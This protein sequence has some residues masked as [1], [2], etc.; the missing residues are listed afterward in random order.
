MSVTLSGDVYFV[1][2][3]PLYSLLRNESI[4]NGYIVLTNADADVYRFDLFGVKI[5]SGELTAAGTG[6]DLSIPLEMQPS[7]VAVCDDGGGNTWKASSIISLENT[8]PT[9]P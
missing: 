1:N 7:P 5:T 8:Q 9:L 4:G 2:Q 3:D 6:E